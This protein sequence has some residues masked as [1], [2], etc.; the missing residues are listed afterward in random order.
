MKTQLTPSKGYHRT[1][2]SSLTR[3]AAFVALV[4]LIGIPLFSSS[5]ASSASETSR[6]VSDTGAAANSNSIFGNFLNAGK[7]RA[8]LPFLPPVQETIETFAA[9]CTTPKSAFLLGETVCAKTNDVDLGFA[10]GRWV[11]WLREDLSIAFGGSGTT[12][13]TANP[14]FFSF[15][16]DQTGTWKVTIAETG[17]PSQTPAVFT[18]SLAPESIA[19]YE[20]TCNLAQN[21]FTLN[22]G[23]VTV[24]AKADA[25]FT[26]TRFIYWV[27]SQGEAIQ[28]DVL[29]SPMASAT[30]TMTEAG[31]FW[32]Y[33][34]DPDGLRSKHGFT[35]SD[36]AEPRVDLSVSKSR[37]SADVVADGFITYEI[38]V[39]NKGPDTASS[40][41]LNDAVPVNTTY[42]S[43]TQDSGPT[44]TRDAET[45][46][47]TWSIASL[48]AGSSA[49]FTFVYQVGSVA[50]GTIITNSASVN[51]TT[52]EIHTPDNTSADF[53]TVITGTS[54]DCVLDCPNDI[55]TTA[56]THG[57]GGGANVTFSAPEGFGNCGAITSNPA[58]GS[59]FPIGTTTVV[60]TSATGGGGCSF[61]VTVVDTAAPTITCPS[62]ITV[63]ANAGQGQAFVPD[64]NGSS[65]NVGTP[66]TT[67]DQPL[68]V[69]GSRE[70][71]EGLTTAY[72]LGVTR[73][74][75]IAQDPSGR[76][77]TCTQIITV[78]PNQVLTITCPSNKTAASPT[79]CNPAT[80]NVGQATSNSQTA[81]ITSE[82]SDGQALNDPYPVGTTTIEWTATD[83]DT[84][85]VSCTQTVTVTGNV[86]TAPTL[87]D[88]PDVNVTTNSCGQIVGETELGTAT[89]SDDCGPVNVTRTGVPPGN[90]FPTGMTTITYT[91]TNSVGTTTKTQTVTVTEDPAVNPTITAPADLTGA[92]AV[93]TGPGATICG[94]FIG[95]ATL[96]SATA[97]DNC[98]GVTVTRTGV[99]AGNIFPVGNTTVTYR[100]TDRSGN[101][102][103]D[104]QTVTVVDNTVPVVTPPGPVT[105]YTGPGATS[106]SVT[107]T[108][109]DGTFGTGSATDNCPGVGAVS[110]S[111]VP[112]GGVFPVG[113]TIL[114]YSATDAHGNTGTA[115]QTVTVI[116]NTPPTITCPMSNIVLEPTCPSGAIAT[117]PA[118]VVGD[119]C[120]VQSQSEVTSPTP[121]LG[122][123]SVFPIG[124][125]TVTRTVT[126]IHGNTASCTF[127]VT[128]KTAAQ[129]IQDMKTAV[130]ALQPPL[131]GTQVQGLLSKLQAALDA[132]NQNK[133]NVACNKLADFI[134]Q[135][136]GYIGNGTLTSAQGQP[137][138]NSANHV[139][140]TIGCTSLPCS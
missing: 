65:S 10:G 117:Y 57:Q 55:V 132:I 93:N 52:G 43:S 75:W 101:F 124:T 11:H 119:N 126:D 111:G 131:S 108:D 59:F 67:G 85:T 133:M 58:S 28:T 89:A 6:L 9:D 99:P 92:N 38:L 4:A 105:L 137:L 113:E 48:P 81:T 39:S 14:Q 138:I 24:C 104:T 60:N 33:F 118:A 30:R 120:G 110:R 41:A 116:D 122:S 31:N 100:A 29:T 20:S 37:R 34:S 140:N 136:Q 98:P 130:Q 3:I 76:Q 62:N 83:T 103:E 86:T 26:G 88:P 112:A 79:G 78:N 121:N 45:P 82:R 139:R 109:L 27:N 49:S 123:G 23:S 44:F 72:P 129:T 63:T 77:A 90:F 74:T 13:I 115:P 84:Q 8:L 25:N 80:V 71:G 53:A 127:T 106:C 5:L 114:T 95:D 40:V 69:T 64:P 125:T 54:N 68:T 7:Q 35:V 56:T 66:T 42:V 102:A 73:I 96:G 134:L 46:T 17:D 15:V 19:T 21:N 70:D 18:V 87:N 22:M 97:S 51:S 1:N 50:A 36:P 32:V 128:V 12:L 91:A 16:P 107:V 2:L 135:V 94:A 61:T 47:T